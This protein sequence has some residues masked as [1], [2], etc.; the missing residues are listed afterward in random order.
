[1]IDVML[2]NILGCRN[3]EMVNLR[4]SKRMHSMLTTLGF[5]R[6]DFIHFRDILDRVS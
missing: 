1:M 4:A 5:K 6:E 3:R 2:K